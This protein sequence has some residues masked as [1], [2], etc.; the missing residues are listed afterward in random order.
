V[1]AHGL[2]GDAPEAIRPGAADLLA[3]NAVRHPLFVP[4]QSLEVLD[5]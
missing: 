4:A 1:V 3:R 2:C 5:R